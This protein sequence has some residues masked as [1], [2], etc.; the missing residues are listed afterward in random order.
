MGVGVC[1]YVSFVIT[2]MLRVV[3][4][5]VSMDYFLSL[6]FI[7]GFFVISMYKFTLTRND[8]AVFD[9]SLKKKNRI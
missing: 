5:G 1:I 9:P 4:H 6:F 7:V 8:K 2:S 3:F